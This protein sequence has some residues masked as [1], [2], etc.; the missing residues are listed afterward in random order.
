MRR[1]AFIAACGLLGCGGAPQPERS[2]VSVH[3]VS[4][5]DRGQGLEAGQV[6]H[7]RTGGHVAYE[8]NNGQ[9]LLFRAQAGAQRQHGF[10]PDDAAT[11]SAFSVSTGRINR[12]SGIEAGLAVFLGSG[13]R[14]LPWLRFMLG[15]MPDFRIGVTFGPDEPLVAV[16]L[17]HLHFGLLFENVE[18][19]MGIASA[20]RVV[21]QE[22][23][24]GE[25][26][27]VA[28]NDEDGPVFTAALR[29][30]LPHF[31]IDAGFL[32]GAFDVAR[33]G[34]FYDFE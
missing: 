23:F 31:G 26:L 34:V 3:G 13:N 29:W 8:Y 14:T 32:A 33:L 25:R 20:G 22:D 28:S 1:L 24:E 10:E 5:T 9:G 17:A 6:R 19:Q 11:L 12:R 18:L 27:Q 4:G 16:N 30:R 15:D 21:D 7:R 2:R